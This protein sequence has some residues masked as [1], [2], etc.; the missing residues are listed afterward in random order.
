MTAPRYK[1]R[2]MDGLYRAMLAAAADPDGEMY[3]RGTD[4]VLVKHT[5]AGHRCSF[6]NGFAG[7][8]TLSEP[9]G[10]LAAACYAAGRTFAKTAPEWARTAAALR[11]SPAR[12][13][14]FDTRGTP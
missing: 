1:D 4:G 13:V 5:G 9:R 14:W 10:T 3:Y 6:W 11:W 7:V 12:K 8:R 2:R